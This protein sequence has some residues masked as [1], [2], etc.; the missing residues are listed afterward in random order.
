M[1]NEELLS[2]LF[3]IS[4]W[5]FKRNIKQ[6]MIVQD[7]LFRKCRRGISR[8]ANW[9][10][11]AYFVYVQAVYMYIML[12]THTTILLGALSLGTTTYLSWRKDACFATFGFLNIDV[13]R[14]LIYPLSFFNSN[15]YQWPNT[16]HPFRKSI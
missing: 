15:L 12:F 6:L 8:I 2:Y 14:V 16:L 9:I 13:E 10:V 7:I 3:L 5:N 11:N 1:K 4:G